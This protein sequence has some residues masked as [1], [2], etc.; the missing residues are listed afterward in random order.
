VLPA[1]CAIVCV[2]SVGAQIPEQYP[3]PL[4]HT[5]TDHPAQ[6]ILLLTVD[7][8]HAS[9]LAS[10]VLRHPHSALANLSAQGVTYTNARTPAANATGGLLALATGGTPISTGILAGVGYDHALSPP[11]SHCRTRGTGFV[12]ERMMATRGIDMT[13]M[14]L[15]RSRGCMPMRPHDLLRVNTIFEIVHEKVGPTAWAANGAATTDL[16]SGPS[17]KGLDEAVA[18]TNDTARVEAVLHWIDGRDAGGLQPKPV[19]ALF[20]MSFSGVLETQTGSASYTDLLGTPSA[21]LE[22][23]IADVDSKIG[24]LVSEL[25]RQKLDRT[26]WVFV[27]AAFGGARDKPQRWIPLSRLADAADTVKPGVVAQTA[28]GSA[29]MVWLNDRSQTRAVAEAYS[30]S[31][32]RLGIRAVVCEERLSLTLNAP[33]TDSRMPDILLEAQPG[34][35]WS[36]P[37]AMEGY[38]GTSDDATHVPLL[39][40]GV[41]LT[42]RKDPTLVPTTQI[43]PLLLRA[44]GLEKF[45]LEALHRE[46]TPALPGVF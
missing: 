31:A 36:G 20:G 29:A 28:G 6:H 27:T 13:A 39:V 32:S 11:G 12:L 18:R 25:K 9:D 26:T 40:S 44:L 10:W 2:L 17:G 21:K 30:R 42:A 19:P 37:E 41:Q 7:G 4:V 34:V 43:A 1:S 15:D 22:Q 14:P 46:H 35:V 33:E 38:G 16:L 5:P 24:R 3:K 23:S 8:L 45:D